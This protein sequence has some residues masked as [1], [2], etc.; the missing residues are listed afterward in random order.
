MVAELACCKQNEHSLFDLPLNFMILCL[1]FWGFL[2]R[3]N[4]IFWYE[5]EGF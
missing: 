1:G 2:P 5:P 4:N 3:K